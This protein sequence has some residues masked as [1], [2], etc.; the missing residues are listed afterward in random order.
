[1]KTD[2]LVS[3][4][5]RGAQSPDRGAATRRAVLALSAAGLLALAFTATVLGLRADWFGQ[6]P[7]SALFLREAYCTCLSIAGL[8]AARRLALPGRRVGALAWGLV[9]P[10]ALMWALAVVTLLQAPAAARPGLILGSTAAVCPWLIAV[11]ATP[12]FV[13]LLWLAR[14]LAPTRLAAA[15]ALAGF[16]SGAC[17]ALIYTLHCPELAA[18]FLA[19]WYLLGMLIPTAVGFVLGPRLLRW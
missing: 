15:G 8:L 3:L 11:V 16:A 6:S 13:A 10:I 19:V 4:L 12:I 9:V 5:A 18:P 17:G 7:A 1:M 2:E 14:G